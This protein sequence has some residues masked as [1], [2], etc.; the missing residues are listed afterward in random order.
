MKLSLIIPFKN[1]IDHAISTLT[2]VLEFLGEREVDFE[3]IAVD[4][5]EDGTWDVLNSFEACHPTV[6]TVKGGHPSG[7]GTAIQAG[8]RMA[9]GDVI[10]PF[11][12]DFSDSL[13]DVTTY[14]KKIQSGYDMVFGSRF[15]KDSQVSGSPRLKTGL[16]YVG[17]QILS[18]MF[19][20]DCCDFTNSFKAYR[21]EVF[22]EMELTSSGFEIV[23]EMP[24]KGIAKGYSYTTVPVHWENRKH[25][26]SKMSVLGII[27]RY[28]LT[29][30]RIW[31][32]CN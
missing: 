23:L 5:S 24:L 3:I 27:P 11:N 12:G 13:V 17:N 19:R 4:D 28:L 29:A 21:K 14:L 18:K 22:N 20:A 31:S 32:N 30:A 7:Y 10:I 15:M 26:K 6:V 9:T 25:G 1:E 16:S 8:L 2:S